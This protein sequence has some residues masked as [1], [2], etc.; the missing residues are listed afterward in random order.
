MQIQ[1]TFTT[2]ANR[3]AFAAKTGYTTADQTTLTAHAALLSLAKSSEGFAS[4]E[5]AEAGT[6]EFIVNSDN[7]AGLAGVATELENLGDGFYRV[8]S[9]DFIALYNANPTAEPAVANIKSERKNEN[10][11]I[12]TPNL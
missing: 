6:N 10:F 11:F 2:S 9:T 7:I 5:Q 4:A 1:I 3:N 12:P 8:S